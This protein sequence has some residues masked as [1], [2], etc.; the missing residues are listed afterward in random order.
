M[1]LADLLGA[2]QL[3]AFIALQRLCGLA[4]LLFD[5]AAFNELALILVELARIGAIA[6]ALIR[7]GLPGRPVF[8]R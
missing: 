7:L 1:A 3:G 4:R 8:F 2:A 6:L 5:L